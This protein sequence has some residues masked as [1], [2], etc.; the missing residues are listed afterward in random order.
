[1]LATLIATSFGL[2]TRAD[3]IKL[4]DGKTIFHNAVITSSDAASVTIRHSTGIARVMIPELPPE[5]RA[6]FQYDPEKARQRLLSEQ[7]QLEATNSAIQS[8]IAG[9]TAK[10]ACEKSKIRLEGKIIQVMEN[11]ILLRQT[12]AFGDP[13]ILIRHVSTTNHADGD[14]VAINAVPVGTWQYSNTMGSTNT[15]R[16]FDAACPD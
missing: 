16:A 3:D 12:N 8:G 1:M 10:E 2:I 14:R 11:S 6:K 13:T 15:V 9:L 5:L 4:A 7:K